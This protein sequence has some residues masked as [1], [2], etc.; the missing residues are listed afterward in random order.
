MAEGN[1]EH[2]VP[3]VCLGNSGL[4]KSEIILGCMA[5]RSPDWQEWVPKHHF[6]RPTPPAHCSQSVAISTRDPATF[7]WRST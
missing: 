5:Y 1:F 7:S 6:V 3:Y 4:K 2:K